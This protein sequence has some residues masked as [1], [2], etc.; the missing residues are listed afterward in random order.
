MIIKATRLTKSNASSRS[1]Y[2]QPA[3]FSSTGGKHGHLLTKYTP[4]HTRRNRTLR[5][6]HMMSHS[7]GAL[8][9]ITVFG[10]EMFHTTLDVTLHIDYPTLNT[11]RALL[12][13]ISISIYHR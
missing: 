3:L 12:E 6:G 2:I 7:R 5:S 10:N 11:Q 13:L 8:S 1:Y 4:N 9:M